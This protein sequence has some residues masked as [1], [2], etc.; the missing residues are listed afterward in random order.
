MSRHKLPLRV[1]LIGCG[2]ISGQYFTNAPRYPQF[3][4]TAVS[5]LDPQ[6]AVAAAEKRGVRSADSPQALIA[7]EAIDLILNLTPPQAHV[8]ITLAALA[9]GKHVYTEKPLALGMNDAGRIIEVAKNSGQRVGCAPD[10][11][12]GAG[13][14]TARRLIDDGAIGRL[15][16]FQAFMYTPGH[17]RWHPAPEFFYKPGGGPMLDMGPYYVTALL[18]LLGPVRRLCG[19]AGIAIAERIIRSEPLAGQ[20][21]TVETPDHYVGCLEFESG[22][23]G[24]LA[25]S[26]AVKGGDYDAA[27]PIV[28]YGTD[29]AM[30]VPDPN[31]F[32]GTVQL[33][34]EGLYHDVEPMAPAGYGRGVGIADMAQAIAEDRPHRCSLEQAAVA[35][36]IMTAFVTA[37]DAG[38]YHNV[39]TPY[40]RPEPLRDHRN[41][42]A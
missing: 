7:D 22:V 12:L 5:D 15:V 13:L 17:E 14:Q 38:R 21:I 11:F 2:N 30:R 42:F 4:I 35:L 28:I 36:E 19:F 3:Q 26:F 34:K 18:N 9:A 33:W 31:G 40:S 32:D 29:G 20:T 1:G 6:R 10:T 8:E 24:M 41:D 39:A 25:Q 37:S 27:H 16:G 23:T